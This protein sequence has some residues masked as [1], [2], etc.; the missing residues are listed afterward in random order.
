MGPRG[1]AKVYTQVVIRNDFFNIDQTSM[2]FNKERTE[3]LTVWFRIFVCFFWKRYHTEEVSRRWIRGDT[4]IIFLKT[5]FTRKM[6]E[7]RFHVFFGYHVVKQFYLKWTEFIRNCE[8]CS[9]YSSP[10]N[11]TELEQSSQFLVNSVSIR[12]NHDIMYS[13]MKKE[14]YMESGLPGI[15]WVKLMSKKNSARVSRGPFHA[16]EG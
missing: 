11:R 16:Y 3:V 13:S 4:S 12:Q 6:P 14:A 10:R 7:F 2:L 8:F 5:R 1:P 15:F 9:N